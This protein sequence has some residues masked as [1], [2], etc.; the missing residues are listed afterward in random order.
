VTGIF[1][2]SY[3]PGCSGPPDECYDDRS[4]RDARITELL[5]ECDPYGNGTFSIG[6]SDDA[7]YLDLAYDED[8][9]IYVIKST[10]NC[11]TASFIQNFRA[12]VI[13][14]RAE[15]LR[16]ACDLVGAALDW[17]GEND[18][19]YGGSPDPA[20][21]ARYVKWIAGKRKGRRPG[22]KRRG[23]YLHYLMKVLQSD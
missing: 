9:D 20:Y 7:V 17:C 6:S 8:E 18:V 11:E 10:L 1:G 22:P 12:P 23:W 19:R 3:P 14:T 13:C 2:W 5:D 15:V 16:E 21:F 4:E